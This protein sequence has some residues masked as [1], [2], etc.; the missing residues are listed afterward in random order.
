MGARSVAIP[1]GAASWAEV[2]REGGSWFM[3]NAQV[4]NSNCPETEAPCV[5]PGCTR[6]LCLTKERSLEEARQAEELARQG[7]IRRG[8]ATIDDLGL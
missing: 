8:E 2:K 3:S 1:R 4:R 7:R 6:S 5:E